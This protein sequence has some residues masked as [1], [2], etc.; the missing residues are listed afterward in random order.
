MDRCV[1]LVGSFPA[2]GQGLVKSFSTVELFLGDREFTLFYEYLRRYN[3]YKADKFR[4]TDPYFKLTGCCDA[5]FQDPGKHPYRTTPFHKFGLLGPAEIS[6]LAHTRYLLSWGESL[7][8]APIRLEVTVVTRL[9]GTRLLPGHSH[10]ECLTRHPSLNDR[11][12]T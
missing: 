8:T 2:F 6:N 12:A 4:N 11:S 10:Q 9:M 1:A 3:S 5:G 7:N